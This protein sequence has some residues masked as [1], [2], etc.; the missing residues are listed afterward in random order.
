MEIFNRVVGHEA[1]GYNIERMSQWFHRH[2]TQR[3]KASGIQGGGFRLAD[4]GTP[5][6]SATEKISTVIFTFQIGID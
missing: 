4:N 2:H 3:R 6:V 5:K 1:Q